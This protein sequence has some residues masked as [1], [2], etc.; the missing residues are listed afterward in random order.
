VWS[1]R[2]GYSWALTAAGCF[3]CRFGYWTGGLK[4]AG[5]DVAVHQASR[6]R[7]QHPPARPRR[8]GYDPPTLL[9]ALA[10]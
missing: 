3:L 9:A 1:G 5:L 6:M 10:P 8:G 2:G 7:G 4:V